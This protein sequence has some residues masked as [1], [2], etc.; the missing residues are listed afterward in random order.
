MG[1]VA[2]RFNASETLVAMLSATKIY[3]V[4]VLVLFGF[5]I[6]FFV[7]T[8]QYR[9]SIPKGSGK[10]CLQVDKAA[11]VKRVIDG[12]EI[13]VEQGKCMVNVRLLGIKS[14]PP[15]RSELAL[16]P[17]GKAAVAFL[18]RYLGEKVT[19]LRKEAKLD[20][21]GRTLARLS[22]DGKDIGLLMVA[23]GLVVVF[24]KFPFQGERLYLAAEEK[25]RAV[26]KGLWAVPL[27]V[28][29]VT[30]WQGH[31]ARERSR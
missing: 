21:R 18:K 4:V 15:V 6:F 29:R 16:Q 7:R 11:T 12:D 25:A 3:W 1:A 20:N 28:N 14:F 10:D 13:V 26:N 17:L 22:A 30:L 19:V 8:E 2:P 23:E 24:R 9:R 27:A 31:W 5:S